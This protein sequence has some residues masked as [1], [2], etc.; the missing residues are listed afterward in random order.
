MK[1]DADG[2][3]NLCRLEECLSGA[4]TKEWAPLEL[5]Q[6]VGH[7]FPTRSGETFACIIQERLHVIEECVLPESQRGFR[8]G[9]ESDVT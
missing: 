7:Q 3:I 4:Y 9:R 2:L 8:K 5:C 6:L 1:A